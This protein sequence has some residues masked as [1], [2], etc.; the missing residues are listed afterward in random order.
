MHESTV[1]IQDDDYAK[2]EISDYVEEK[3]ATGPTVL[4]LTLRDLQA[5]AVDGVITN[6][7]ASKLWA[8]LSATPTSPGFMETAVQPLKAVPSP[9]FGFVN[10]LYYFGGLVAISAMG[11]FMTIGFE[12]MGAAG[13]LAIGLGYF[14][15]CLKVADH[16]KS[17]ALPVPAGLLATLAVVLV[18]LV[19]WSAQS[20][21]GLW[22]PG[23]S[24]T[25]RAYYTI[26]NWRWMTL[27]F[28][29]L[30]AGVV[31]LW[32]YRLPFMVMPVAVTVWYL[33]MDIAHALMQTN[34]FD[35]QFSR[36]VSVVFGMAT[37]ALAMW[38]DVRTRLSRNTEWQ[39]D[40]AFWLYLFGA[41]MFWC[42]LSLQN[43]DSE[44]G[45]F[46]YALLNVALVLGGAAIGRRVFTVYG[47]LGV[48]MYL[49]HLSHQ[50]FR[51]S[52]MFPFALTLIGLAVVWL[53]VVWQRN[54]AAINARLAQYVPAGL[55][56]R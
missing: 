50:V 55:R 22:P 1:F 11:L 51:N 42:G 33:S 30:A 46:L 49:G 38:V 28:V 37:V 20:L 36:D 4:P 43:S 14:V 45:K 48:A 16:F 8:R 34:G 31:M 44:V 9:K 27:E 2:T 40:F 32:R 15:A 13:L 25:F 7:Q 56:P 26:I 12:S 24:G 17:R 41:T 3:Q 53:G 47:A 29:T 10:V 6:L 35:W 23:G 19:V 21:A 39:Q 54:E 52:M 5:A 18:P